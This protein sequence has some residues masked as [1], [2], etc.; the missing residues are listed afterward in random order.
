[1]YGA[2]L[3]TFRILLNQTEVNMDMVERNGE[4]DIINTTM[5]TTEYVATLG[6]VV[7]RTPA[8][9][10]SV[11]KKLTGDRGQQAWRGC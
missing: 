11:A 5:Y 7:Y 3:L 1:M 2:N 9:S 8:V 4:W 10:A 6:E